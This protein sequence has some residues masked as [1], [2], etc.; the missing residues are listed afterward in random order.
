MT[1]RQRTWV[2]LVPILVATLAAP[3]VWAKRAPPVDVAPIVTG[4]IR[5]EAPHFSNPCNQNGGCVVAY[6][7]TSNAMLWFV[8][9]YCTHYDPNLEQDVQDVFI[10]ALSVDSGTLL[11]TNE[12][13]QHFAIDPVSRQVTG[14]PSGCTGASGSACALAKMG[15]VPTRGGLLMVISAAGLAAILARSRRARP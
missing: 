4:G 12:R 8:Q 3:N 6:D 15:H 9:V 7:N 10:T 14:G 2:V 11:V 13:G 5:Y 1:I